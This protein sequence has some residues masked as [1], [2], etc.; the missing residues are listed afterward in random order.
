LTFCISILFSLPSQA[1]RREGENRKGGKRRGNSKKR[2]RE[3]RSV[4]G[5][6]RGRENERESLHSIPTQPSEKGGLEKGGEKREEEESASSF[7]FS[8]FPGSSGRKKG[9]WGREGKKRK[10]RKKE[11]KEKTDFK[12][13]YLTLLLPLK[14]CWM[15]KSPRGKRGR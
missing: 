3:L 13:N 5:T 10:R 7:Y 2:G 14:T 1:P 8:A 11:K 9:I 15:E 4:A 12:L 6:Y